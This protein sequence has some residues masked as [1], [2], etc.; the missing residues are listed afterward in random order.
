M[1][2]LVLALTF[3]NTSS[4]FTTCN[5]QLHSIE[6]KS[7]QLSLSI[8]RSPVRLGETALISGR[9]T[10]VNAESYISLDIA[11]LAPLCYYGPRV[12]TQVKTDTSGKF[13]YAWRP[14]FAG[15]YVIKAKWQ[16]VEEIMKVDVVVVGT[17]NFIAIPIKFPNYSY[18]LNDDEAVSLTRRAVSAMSNNFR[19]SSYGKFIIDWDVTERFTLPHEVGYYNSS[20]SHYKRIL[21]D[22][23][24]VADATVDFSKYTFIAVVYNCYPFYAWMKAWARASLGLTYRIETGEGAF[25]VGVMWV[26]LKSPLVALEHGFP[27]T[28]ELGHNLGLEHLAGGWDIMTDGCGNAAE[29]CAWTRMYLGWIDSS[30]IRE[31]LPRSELRLDDDGEVITVE[32]LEEASSGIKVVKIP[33][34]L[35]SYFL[36][37]VRRPVGPDETL[38]SD[39]I[40]AIVYGVS[41]ELD[42]RGC[43]KVGATSSIDRF[44]R[45]EYSEYI[46]PS[47]YLKVKVVSV[48]NSSYQ[49]KVVYNSEAR[50]TLTVYDVGNATVILDGSRAQ[51]TNEDGVCNFVV[52]GGVHTVQTSNTISWL[53]LS[54]RQFSITQNYTQC[55]SS[56]NPS[57][58]L[59]RDST[60]VEVHRGG[61]KGRLEVRLIDPS[62]P[63][64]SWSFP[65]LTFKAIVTS[66]GK[67][68]SNALVS[69]FLTRGGIT[70]PMG[71]LHVKTDPAGYVEVKGWDP[72]W[73]RERTFVWW[74]E[75]RKIGYEGSLSERREVTCF[76]ASSATS[77]AIRVL[78]YDNRLA[79]ELGGLTTVELYVKGKASPVSVM[80]IDNR[81]EVKFKIPW[82]IYNATVWHDPQKPF[83]KKEFWGTFDVFPGSPGE[84]IIVKRRAPYILDLRSRQMSVKAGEP[85][86]IDVIVHFYAWGLTTPLNI[87]VDLTIKDDLGKVVYEKISQSAEILPDESKTF[88]FEYTPEREG[89]HYGFARC[90]VVG[91]GELLCT[92]NYDWKLLFESILPQSL[93]ITNKGNTMDYPT[94][95]IAGEPYTLTIRWKVVTKSGGVVS[96]WIADVDK[97]RQIG[98]TKI[99][100]VPAGVTENSTS[101]TIET[102]DD[103]RSLWR[104]EANVNMVGGFLDSFQWNVS[105]EPLPF[106]FDIS[107]F[108]EEQAIRLN[109]NATY[110]INVKLIYGQTHSVTLHSDYSPEIPG[111]ATL[112]P[113]DGYPTFNSTI[114]VTPSTHTKPGTYIITITGFGGGRIH[115]AKAFLHIY[116]E[117]PPITTIKPTP[118]RIEARVDLTKVME[119]QLRE[120]KVNVSIAEM[121]RLKEVDVFIDKPM[122]AE[123]P[124]RFN[125]TQVLENNV[126]K[127]ELELR[128]FNQADA[129]CMSIKLPKDVKMAALKPVD[130]ITMNPV[131]IPP[132]MPPSWVRI[133][134]VV[135]IGPSGVSFDRPVVLNFTYT[136]EIIRKLRVNEA[137]L[138]IASYD[139]ASA[140]WILLDSKVNPERNFVYAMITHLTP[141]TVV[142]REVALSPEFALPVSAYAILVVAIVVAVAVAEVVLKRRGRY[143][144]GDGGL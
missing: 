137:L 62:P 106:D 53:N 103:G 48:V 105:I 102:P 88:T 41:E 56:T 77:L 8:S 132:K 76:P 58:I 138:A 89:K 23:I 92:D 82:K 44:P 72:K 55:H 12:S 111:D 95:S 27:F 40:G 91:D 130:S 144:N 50:F 122:T 32:P 120:I 43:I 70:L 15:H 64:G 123:I 59:I 87:K 61:L 38:P 14:A 26:D 9:L 104:I 124:I 78:N 125:L 2:F 128:I 13:S 63:N 5:A 115:Y 46:H 96:V 94:F 80:S 31:I 121:P 37:E 10:G 71:Q 69:F 113:Y 17:Y 136:D 84:I 98:Y 117:P 119:Q 108:P 101:F 118:E 45:Q 140:N 30:Q 4:N 116:S 1:I 36:I 109:E 25:D 131:L 127:R 39:A 83:H 100:S 51:T 99:Y 107:V 11:P 86:T 34:S 142:Q 133:L 114:T 42:S 79:S 3:I 47:T 22:A 75:A 6:G 33:L 74:A 21:E 28:H 16:D 90:Y 85:I 7:V 29:P 112:V 52:L 67:P 139:E 68:V 134:P 93:R 129:T 60:R 126:V 81:S 65:P 24:A 141:Y 20:D 19:E 35:D 73:D 143:F 135:D 49:I 57:A 54:F 66:D 110:L 18:E 97:N